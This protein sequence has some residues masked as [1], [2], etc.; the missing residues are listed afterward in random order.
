VARYTFQNQGA[1]V[2]PG[3]TAA[4]KIRHFPV[5]RF[6]RGKPW[7]TDPRHL[8]SSAAAVREVLDLVADK[9]SF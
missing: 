1:I 4:G 9:W 8:R 3:V 7:P 6:L 5:P 2:E